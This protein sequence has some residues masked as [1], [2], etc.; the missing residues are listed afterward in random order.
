MG[1]TGGECG[2]EAV[3]EGAFVCAAE[4]V[5]ERGRDLPSGSFPFDSF[6]VAFESF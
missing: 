1:V 3:V 5:L 4:E 6:N 2:A